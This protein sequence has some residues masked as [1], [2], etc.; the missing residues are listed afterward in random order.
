MTAPNEEFQ[1]QLKALQDE[2]KAQLAGRLEELDAAFAELRDSSGATEIRSAME[3]LN[4]LS[5]KLTGSAGTFG[6]MAVSEA[7]QRL[8]THCQS[9]LDDDNAV[10]TGTEKIA[11]LVA[12]VRNAVEKEL[13]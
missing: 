4:A 5:H 3:T 6:F 12:E 1:D 11:G 2:F 10:E 13:N 8:E 9:L 7:A